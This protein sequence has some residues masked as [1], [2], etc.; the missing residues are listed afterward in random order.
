MFYEGVA[1]MI[2]Q[3]LIMIPTLFPL[4]KWNS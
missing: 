1:F 3:A 4:L 2:V